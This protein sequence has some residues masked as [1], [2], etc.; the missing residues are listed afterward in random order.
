MILSSALQFIVQ[1]SANMGSYKPKEV[2][3]ILWGFAAAGADDP[4]FVK[5]AAKVSRTMFAWVLS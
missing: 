2:A 4:A 1:V 3:R 5:A